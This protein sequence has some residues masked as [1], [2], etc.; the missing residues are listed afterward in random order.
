VLAEKAAA[1]GPDEEEDDEAAAARRERAVRW[2]VRLLPAA[3]DGAAAEWVVWLA[4][5]FELFFAASDEL[6]PWLKW[7]AY[8][9]VWAALLL[10]LARRSRRI[11]RLREVLDL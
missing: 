5:L 10:L 11:A 4:R 1:A 9:V 2:A 8:D 3:R 6:E 7:K